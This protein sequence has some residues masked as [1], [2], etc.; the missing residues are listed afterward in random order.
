[1][2]KF[3]LGIQTE[4]VVKKERLVDVACDAIDVIRAN[5]AA[6]REAFS[7][8]QRSLSD[9]PIQFEKVRLYDILVWS[10]EKWDVREDSRAIY[11]TPETAGK[12][13]TCASAAVTKR[14]SESGDDMN[15]GESNWHEIRTVEEF[16]RV[17]A[18]GRGHVVITDNANPNKIHNPSCKWLKEAYF[19]EK[20]VENDCRNG[21][22]YWT[23]DPGF[24]THEWKARRCPDC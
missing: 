19:Q 24:A 17:L 13:L 23:D 4:N 12:P 21:H 7:V 8:L 10:T 5:L 6:N 20:V 9:L 1:V 2:I 11:G 22:Y 14:A 3:L 15:A 16:R 18:E